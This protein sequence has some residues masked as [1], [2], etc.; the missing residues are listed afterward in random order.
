MKTIWKYAVP[1][2]E[3]FVLRLPGGATILSVQTQHGHPH[4]W[5][6]VDTKAREVTRAF[7][8]VGTGHAI[9]ENTTRYCGTFQESARAHHACLV[10]HLYECRAEKNK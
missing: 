6:E 8:L 10:F 2:A 5:V 1:I 4:M 9:P 7:C 3:H